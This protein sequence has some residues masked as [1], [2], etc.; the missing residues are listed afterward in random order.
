MSTNQRLK[1]DLLTEKQKDKILLNLKTAYEEINNEIAETR[2]L[3]TMNIHAFRYDCSNPNQN[4]DFPKQGN[5]SFILHLDKFILISFSLSFYKNQDGTY[6]DFFLKSEMRS[7]PEGYLY[8]NAI[9]NNT[10]YKMHVID[11][12]EFI[13]S[14]KL[15]GIMT[16]KKFKSDINELISKFKKSSKRTFNEVNIVYNYFGDVML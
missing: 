16:V 14:D 6:S 7:F 9:Y 12:D 8:E 1:N 4:G 13:L 10:K 15:D 11:L 2:S 5:T 3:I